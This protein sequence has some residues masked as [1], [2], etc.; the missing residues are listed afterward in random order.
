MDFPGAF[1]NCIMPRE[2]QQTLIRLKRFL[3][4]VM[5]SIDTRF[6]KFVSDNGTMVPKLNKAL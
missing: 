2:C 1:L 3:T 5:V 6:L 4:E